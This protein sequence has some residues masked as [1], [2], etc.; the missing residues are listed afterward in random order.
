MKT[1]VIFS[2]LVALSAAIPHSNR[3][4][5]GLEA[6]EGSAPYQVSLQV[7]NFHFCGGSILNEY[8][9]LTAAHCLGYDF[10]VVV[11]TNKLDQP[12]ER[13]LVEQTF[14]HQFDQESLRHDLALVKVSSPIEFN[15]YVQPIPLGETYVGGG[16]VARLTGWGRLGANLNGPNELQEL[17]T[18]TLSHQQ[19]VRQQIYPVYDSQL[20]TFVGSGRGA[21]NGDSGGPLVVNGELHGVVSWG[22]PCAV[23]L[24]D[25]F[26]RVSHYADWIRETMENN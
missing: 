24:P 23:G 17:N 21:C 25:V 18:V 6:A 10:D 19:C 1:A 13:Y 8:W 5:G 12:G 7:G 2:A 26:T 15:D 9:V 3:V 14:V 22:I 20:C 11:G 4:V 16:E